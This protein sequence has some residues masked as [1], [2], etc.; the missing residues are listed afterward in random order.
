MAQSENTCR[1][2]GNPIPPERRERW[3]WAVTCGR[4]CSDANAAALGRQARRRYRRRRRRE[5]REKS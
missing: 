4:E 1:M 3:S 2:C 5:S